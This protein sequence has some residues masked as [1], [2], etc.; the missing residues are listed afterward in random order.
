ML[1]T[2]ICMGCCKSIRSQTPEDIHPFEQTRRVTG[3]H[4][5]VIEKYRECIIARYRSRQRGP[6]GAIEPGP[7]WCHQYL[8]APRRACSSGPLF[9]LLPLLPAVAL[10]FGSLRPA[11]SLAPLL[12]NLF[13]R[14]FS[15]TTIRDVCLLS[16]DVV[17]PNQCNSCI[18]LSMPWKVAKRR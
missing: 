5:S 7:S 13:C 15:I 8:T 17:M 11:R 14:C 2:M 4:E 16:D 9:L 18:L 3:Y 12:S 1:F 10:A 6:A